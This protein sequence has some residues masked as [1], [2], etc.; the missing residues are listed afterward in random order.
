MPIYL[1]L[2]EWRRRLSKY[3]AMASLSQRQGWSLA[4]LL[5]VFPCLLFA[6]VNNDAP[7]VTYRTGTSEVRVTFFA[8]DENNRLVQAVDRNDFAVVDGDMVIRDFRS[9]TRSDE[10][11]LDI[12]V[13]VDTSESV[14]PRFRAIA[15]QVLQLISHNHSGDDLSII[16]F[17]GLRPSV[18]CTADCGGAATEGKI[19]SL[20]PAGATPLFDSLAFS[21]RYIADRHTPGVR[22]VMILLSD[23]N[24]TISGTSARQALDAVIGTGA[25]LYTINLN[26]SA[27]DPT[28]SFALTE[29]AEAT[30]GRSFSAQDDA[31]EVLETALADLRASY[32]VT[33][34]LPSRTAGF[35]SLRILPKHN[36]NLHFHCRRGYF[37]DE[38]R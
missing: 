38:G 1:C 5:S 21:A 6:G 25:L 2:L 37:Y 7:D 22:Q 17:A 28:G 4:V 18:L 33:Y 11:K 9:L 34:P 35:H 26:K 3:P 30:G 15:D 16:T 32:V 10:T 24:D 12:V 29:M 8:T 13:L 31:T 23:G 36:L 14:A 27:R 19:R 20:N